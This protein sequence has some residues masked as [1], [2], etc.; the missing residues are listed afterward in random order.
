MNFNNNSYS[1]LDTRLLNTLLALNTIL[2]PI[3]AAKGFKPTVATAQGDTYILAEN[4]CEALTKFRN[5]QTA[6][7]EHG[8][9]VCPK[10]IVLG[11]SLI[12]TTGECLVV[13]KNLEYKLDCIAR[14]VDVLMKLHIV[15]DIPISKISKLVWIF[16]E[17]Y[18][19]Q[20]EIQHGGY[21]CVNKLIDYLNN[22][23]Q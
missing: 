8:I 14:G 16:I 20:I 4:R 21:L 5:I 22:Y 2:I 19:Y 17:K 12:N 11:K 23:R 10:L 9:S 18:L 15:L 6:H 1:F 13:Y 7:D 3:K